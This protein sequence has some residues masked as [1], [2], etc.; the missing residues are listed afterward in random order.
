M[1]EDEKPNSSR[2]QESTCSMEGAVVR[3]TKDVT[4]PAVVILQS[5]TLLLDI[6]IKQRVAEIWYATE[7]SKLSHSNLYYAII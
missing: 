4:F 2:N 1:T 3:W 5:A 7:E 6:K